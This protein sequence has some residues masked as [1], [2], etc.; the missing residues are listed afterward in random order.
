MRK[1]ATKRSSSAVR[2]REGLL[3]MRVIFIRLSRC[4]HLRRP[5][6]SQDP[7]SGLCPFKHA[8]RRAI[9]ATTAW[10]YGS[11]LSPGR[12]RELLSIKLSLQERRDE[13]RHGA[14]EIASRTNEAHGGKFRMFLLGEVGLDLRAHLLARHVELQR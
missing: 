6:E 8:G 1:G 10:G 4:H 2:E 7:Y 14:G 3:V 9:V 12:R 13:Q 11:W 5:G